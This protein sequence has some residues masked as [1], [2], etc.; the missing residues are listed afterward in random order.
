MPMEEIRT[1]H[2]QLKD[3]LPMMAEAMQSSRI[4]RQERR[5]MPG[6]RSRGFDRRPMPDHTASL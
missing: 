1:E 3:D 4:A 5:L 6:T 2:A